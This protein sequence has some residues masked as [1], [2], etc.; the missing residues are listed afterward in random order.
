MRDITAMFSS[1]LITESVSYE[2][3]H[4]VSSQ[5]RANRTITLLCCGVLAK[6]DSGG[7]NYGHIDRAS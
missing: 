7:I 2:T 1:G 6:L 4:Q 3:T 5:M